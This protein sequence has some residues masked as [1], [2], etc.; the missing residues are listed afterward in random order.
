[1][2]LSNAVKYKMSFQRFEHCLANWI[3][4]TELSQLYSS[5]LS[6]INWNVLMINH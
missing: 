5:Q 3:Q 4:F 6:E 2:F 1:M